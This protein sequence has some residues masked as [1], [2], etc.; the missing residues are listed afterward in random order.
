M[1]VTGTYIYGWL[2]VGFLDS[3]HVLR[4]DSYVCGLFN[5]LD[6]DEDFVSS[7]LSET[8]KPVLNSPHP[9]PLRKYSSTLNDNCINN[10]EYR[11]YF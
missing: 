10:I 9:I 5:V 7:L 4:D 11:K 1:K 6:A 2:V 8:V 3:A